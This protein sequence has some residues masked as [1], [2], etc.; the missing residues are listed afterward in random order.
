MKTECFSFFEDKMTMWKNKVDKIA[1]TKIYREKE[2]QGSAYIFSCFALFK[3][4]QQALFRVHILTFFELHDIIQINN[5]IIAYLWPFSNMVK[6]AFT[7]L[8]SG[9]RRVVLWAIK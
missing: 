3:Y 4:P 7:S 1:Y 2:K 9:R 6:V 8:R 5:I